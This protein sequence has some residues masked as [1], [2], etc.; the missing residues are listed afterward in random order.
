MRQRY[1]AFSYIIIA[2]ALQQIKTTYATDNGNGNN[3]VNP[4]LQLE[5][6]NNGNT[7]NNNNN[8]KNKNGNKNKIDDN[9]SATKF[10]KKN[11]YDNIELIPQV[12][13]TQPR[14]TYYENFL[15]DD[16]CEYFKN[17]APELED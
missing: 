17:K 9:S 15:T 2:F 7:L 5:V 13:S 3:N 14:V 1:Q 8:N 10:L 12:I 16:E 11:Y 4:L 6:D